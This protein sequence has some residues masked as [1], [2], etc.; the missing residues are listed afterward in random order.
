MERLL[1]VRFAGVLPLGIFGNSGNFFEMIAT[2]N[3]TAW[4][5]RNCLILLN[6]TFDG[7]S[8]ASEAA[9]GKN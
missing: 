6:I 1:R 8:L 5:D 3:V 7:L 4:K 9:T 2:D